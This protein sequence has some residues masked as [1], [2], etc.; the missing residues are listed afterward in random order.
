[1]SSEIGRT[2]VQLFPKNRTFN[3]LV[4][5]AVVPA[6]SLNSRRTKM[7]IQNNGA[8]T[9]EM[10]QDETSAFGT[11]IQ[12]ISGATYIDDAQTASTGKLFLVSSGGSND[13]RIREE[14]HELG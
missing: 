3:I 14:F 5:A 2:L 1:M 11:G 12:I 13:V 9:V 6:L 7:I 10:V 8:L 4:G